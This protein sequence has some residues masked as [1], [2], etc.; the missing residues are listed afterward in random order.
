MQYLVLLK[1]FQRSLFI[2]I[3][4][5]VF[6][7]SKSSRGT[8]LSYG[9]FV[10]KDGI[11]FK[12]YAP[13]SY[14]V[15]LILFD[16]FDDIN[17]K[18]IP[19]YRVSNGDW[20]LFVSGIGLGTIYGY[21]L[22]GPNNVDSVIVA[23]P[24]SKAAIT[25]N[26]WRHVAKSLVIDNNFAWEGDKWLNLDYNDLIIYETHVRDMTRHPSSE[27]M[28]PGTYMGFIEKD[29]KG[30]IEYL[31]K[32]GINAVQLLPVWEYANIE[33]PFKKEV[34]GMFNNWNPYERNHWGYM[35]TF[36]F[37][38]ESY[39]A[40]DGV[41]ELGEWNGRSGKAVT[42]LKQLVKELHKN[43]IAVILDVVINHVSNYDLHPLKYI[44][45]KVYFKLDKNG[46]F[47]SQCCGNLLNTDNKKTRQLILESLKYWMTNYHID[48]FR[49][50][51]AHLLSAETAK[52]IYQELK[53]IN[54]NVIIYGEAWDNRNAEFSQ[55]NWGSF[56]DR[57]RD[58]LR[59]DLHNYENK[60]FLFGRYRKG[61]SKNN[62]KLIINGSTQSAGGL[63][64]KHYHS[65]N[66][67]EVHDNYSFNDYLRMSSGEN[68]PED[69][70][71]DKFEHISLSEKLNKM[72]RVGALLLFTSRGIPLIHQ[73]Q[74]WGSSKIIFNEI[75]TDHNN[76][77][78]DPNPYN[79]DNKTNWIDWNELT[80]NGD[81]VDVY[82]KLIDIRKSYFQF[83]MN[84]DQKFCFIDSDNVYCLGYSLNDT[85]LVC[86]NSDG[87]S[88]VKL[89]LPEG[90]WNLLFSTN[91]KF[92]SD[93]K[94][95]KQ[96]SLEPISG[97][98]LK[99]E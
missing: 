81:I 91:K 14:S 5:L 67:L 35:P 66:F 23:D 44:D 78:M 92:P 34:D 62:L 51:Q 24:Y 85:I 70:I 32:L 65:I 94:F 79:K 17:G 3:L 8:E 9:A 46:N 74:E 50:D 30:G 6:S 27:V 52:L 7:C 43:K 75:N 61:E 86:L 89:D 13:R 4:I 59:G 33:I 2:S 38:P 42:E 88:T 20:E 47:L 10:E 18:P 93:D 37:A 97:L 12:L 19:M 31:K 58:V 98:I 99:R 72:N 55:M 77:K 87:K 29:Q 76:G 60:G 39:Y 25:Q 48:G 22:K 83:K 64:S 49:F 36:F 57:F 84:S 56:N 54:P 68:N 28:F 15:D 95:D 26:S 63:Y 90:K 69:I 73:G 45:K 82:E 71:V 53:K 40:T 1:Y 96:I 21:K 41:G 80:Y 16:N 11:R